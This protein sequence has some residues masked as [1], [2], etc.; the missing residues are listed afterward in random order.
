MIESISQTGT[1]FNSLKA[2][3]MSTNQFEAFKKAA[4]VFGFRYTSA[5]M[6][7]PDTY[8]VEIVTPYTID[9]DAYIIGKRVAEVMLKADINSTLF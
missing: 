2:I 6:I 7:E 5:V 3:I 8:W 4:K 1:G 9:Q